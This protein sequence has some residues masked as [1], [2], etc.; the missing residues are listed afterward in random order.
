MP[1]PRH[2]PLSALF[3]RPFRDVNFRRVMLFLGCWQ[4]V[5]N[6][7]LPLFPVY[8]V[9]QLN[10]GITTAIALG[11]VSQ[12]AMIAAVPLWSRVSDQWSNKTVIALA[13]PLFLCCPVGWTL[14]AL[15]APHAMTLPILVL[16][17]CVLGAALAGLDLAS[18][19]IVLKLAPRGESTVF[20]GANGLIKAVCAGCAPLIGG[21]L[22][23]HLTR[24]ELPFL[25]AWAGSR[26]LGLHPWSF[27]FL[28]TTLLGF[29]ALMRLARVEES[30]EVRLGVVLAAAR[31]AAA[32]VLPAALPGARPLEL[33]LGDTTRQAG[34]RALHAFGLPAND[35]DDV[36]TALAQAEERAAL[37]RAG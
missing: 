24:L 10:Y 18:G 30:G 16:L 37:R 21:F 8:L 23:D 31:R 36:A 5:A 12:L 20:L 22:I 29:F 14:A 34:E 28:A 11:I 35:G 9:K 13:G 17:Q 33:R 15:P 3:A 25:P 26:I 1:A 19:N 4:F 27:F 2:T 6:L 32:A 7:A